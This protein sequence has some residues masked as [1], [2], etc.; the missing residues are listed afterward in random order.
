LK[1]DDS[2]YETWGIL[3]D[4]YYYGGHRSDAMES[5]KKAIS[6]AEQKLKVNSKDTDVLGD[7]AG[8]WSMLGN[9]AQALDY[10]DRALVGNKDKELLFQ[11][12]LVYN[13]LHETGTA[14]E[15]LSK[16]LAAGYSKSVASKT[17]NLDDLHDNLRYQAL[18]QQK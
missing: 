3:G 1:L 18:I 4:C 16:A 15:W 7:M 17:P 14:L 5:Y 9:R 2:D 10:L 8:Y 13:Q 11:A 12:A 6:L